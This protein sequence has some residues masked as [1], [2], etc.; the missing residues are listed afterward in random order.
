MNDVRPCSR[1]GCPNPAIATMTFSYKDATA[2]IGALSQKPVPGAL[3]LCGEHAA[4]ATVPIGWQLV[5]LQAE[6]EHSA[7]E[8]AE[9]AR[10]DGLT[11]LADAL[12]EAE[13]AAKE[14]AARDREAAQRAKSRRRRATG[15]LP[16]PWESHIELPTP[17]PHLRVIDGGANTLPPHDKD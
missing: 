2:V 15:S 11:A 14:K 7:A 8:I 12:R 1:A 3:D 13:I 10:D 6:Y 4:S 17:R 16:N 9:A 5:R